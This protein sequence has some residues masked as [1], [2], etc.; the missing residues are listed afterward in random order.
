MIFIF[1]G[2]EARKRE[3][4]KVCIALCN[5]CLFVRTVVCMMR[6]FDKMHVCFLDDQ[7]FCKT[8]NNSAW[9]KLFSFSITES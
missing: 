2:K 8:F 7:S 3:L 9:L 1:T 6:E 4:K 5:V